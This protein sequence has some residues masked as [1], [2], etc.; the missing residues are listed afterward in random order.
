MTGRHEKEINTGIY[1][2]RRVEVPRE[3]FTTKP[4]PN[5]KTRLADIERQVRHVLT[6][7]KVTISRK[8]GWPKDK[9]DFPASAKT[10]VMDA[11]AILFGVKA[12]RHWLGQNRAEDAVLQA[13]VL[14]RALERAS[15][16]PF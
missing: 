3:G 16:R 7:H 10:I 8:T 9:S 11:L 13:I 6:K 15:V 5:L 12:V 1:V 14:G 4:S 2:S